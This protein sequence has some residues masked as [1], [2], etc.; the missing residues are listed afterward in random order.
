M[1]DVAAMDPQSAVD[2]LLA[3]AVEDMKSGGVV[4]LTTSKAFSAA[5]VVAPAEEADA[6]PFGAGPTGNGGATGVLGGLTGREGERGLTGRAPV[7]GLIGGETGGL[8]GGETGRPLGAATSAGL[9]R[10]TSEG[11]VNAAK[12]ETG[13]Q[14]EDTD[15]ELCEAEQFGAVM[16]PPE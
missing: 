8:T 9:S 6:E 13:D 1:A 4:L 16:F 10:G 7:G 5:V 3:T 2:E 14:V 12:V 15:E 11:T